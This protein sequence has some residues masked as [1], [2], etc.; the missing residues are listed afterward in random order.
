MAELQEAVKRR[1][2]ELRADYLRT[3]R[4]GR[5][6]RTKADE[7]RIG[8]IASQEAELQVAG[9]RAG[10]PLVPDRPRTCWEVV[11]SPLYCAMKVV[12]GDGCAPTDYDIP[13]DLTNDER[14]LREY[15][16]FIRL[17]DVRKTSPLSA[18]LTRL[19]A[20]GFGDRLAE[21]LQQKFPDEMQEILA[22]VQTATHTAAGKGAELSDRQRDILQTLFERGSFD[23]DHRLT[24]DEVVEEV[25]GKG[26]GNSET[27][28]VPIADLAR[29][30]LVSTK[31]GRGGGVWLTL[32]GS[33]HIQQ[34][35]EM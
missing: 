1:Y 19:D 2:E 24:T 35:R 10:I 25:C 3:A 4:A 22:A 13:G 26:R 31:E 14:A 18:E 15:L 23:A 16:T 30:K 29:R 9:E 33:A 17:E 20:E 11:L 7:D 28:K 21:I 8:Q 5:K 27:F 34:A 32:Q 12:I 6:R